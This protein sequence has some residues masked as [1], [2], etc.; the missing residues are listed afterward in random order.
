MLFGYCAE[1]IKAFSEFLGV[2]VDFPAKLFLLL[3]G[4]GRVMVY[5]SQIA[6]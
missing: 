2:F 1:K 4:K 3:L 5:F 6:G